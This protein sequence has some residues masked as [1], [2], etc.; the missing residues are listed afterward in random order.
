MNKV[1]NQP[2]VGTTVTLFPEVCI[3]WPA[4]ARRRGWMQQKKTISPIRQAKP[5]NDPITA[6][7]IDPTGL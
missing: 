5:T 7:T 2:V 1:W 4:A 3:T 6:P